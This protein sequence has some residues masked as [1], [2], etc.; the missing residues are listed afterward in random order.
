MNKYYSMSIDILYKEYGEANGDRKALIKKIIDYRKRLV[1]LDTEYKINVNKLNTAKP[2]QRDTI[3]NNS[4]EQEASFGS[5]MDNNSDPDIDNKFNEEINNDYSNNKLMERMECDKHI[6]GNRKKTN[7][8]H[9]PYMS[10]RDMDNINN[11][12]NINEL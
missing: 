7:D 4:D 12:N 10:S 3:L 1:Q 5:L 9:K 8:M 11:V 2:A 6:Y